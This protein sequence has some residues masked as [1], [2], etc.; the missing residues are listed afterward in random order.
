MKSLDKSST[1]RIKITSENIDCISSDY[2]Y[3]KEQLTSK[4]FTDVYLVYHI[5]TKIYYI[6]GLRRH[7]HTDIIDNLDEFKRS[8]LLYQL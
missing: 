6:S 8:V 1:I 4:K 5:R 2:N 3:K 7:E